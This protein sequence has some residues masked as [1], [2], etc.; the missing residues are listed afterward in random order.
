MSTPSRLNS[1]PINVLALREEAR[2]ELESVLAEQTGKIRLVLDPALLP[3]VRLVVT[4]GSRYLREHNVDSIA[5]LTGGPLSVG[6]AGTVLFLT[7]TGAAQVA[8]VVDK[9]RELIRTRGAAVNLHVCFV[10]RRTFAA[11]SALREAGV[12]ADVKTSEWGLDVLPL[13]D[14]ILTMVGQENILVDA[15]SGDTGSLFYVTRALMKM[16]ATYGTIP[17]VRSKGRLAKVVLDGLVRAAREEEAASARGSGSGGTEEGGAVTAPARS[18]IDMLVLLDRGV[19]L[20]TPLIT[21]LSFEALLR[22]T[23]GVEYLAAS[24]DASL[25][26]DPVDEAE[27]GSKSASKK[28]PPPSGKITLH[29]NSND[30]LYCSIRDANIRVAALH[31]S[32]RARELQHF[33]DDIRRRNN[34]IDIASIQKIVK[35][36]PSHQAES[37]SLRTFVE[38][39][40]K[41]QAHTNDAAFSERWQ[42]E[43]SLLDEERRKDVMD[44]VAES[45]AAGEPLISTLRL[46][47][48][49]SVL[50][51]GLKPKDLD[52]LKREIGATYGFPALFSLQRLE[53]AGLLGSGGGSGGALGSM[54]VGNAA[55]GNWAALRKGFNL[56]ADA[57][58]DDAAP[59]DLHFLTSGYAPLSVRLIQHAVTT[60]WESIAEVMRLLPGPAFSIAQRTGAKKEAAEEEGGGAAAA[61][62]TVLVCYIGGVTHIEISGLRFLAEKCARLWTDRV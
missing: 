23:L 1:S 33:R 39:C 54:L 19:D 45:I 27:S 5:E 37:K 49:A 47:C 25:V 35:A 61:R 26:N 48:F 50:A 38:L 16:Q 58:D 20:V 62:K 59:R 17:A 18:E 44:V 36:I 15:T 4:E 40:T 14:D 60:G 30:K 11:E 31:L 24:V 46:L 34:D 22:E 2:A 43:R 57:T 53:A 12:H 28:A 52:A 9:V 8:L 6:D 42:L 56:V 13:D 29:L 10:P 7:R 21:P 55:S 32:S 41:L 3:V 51:G